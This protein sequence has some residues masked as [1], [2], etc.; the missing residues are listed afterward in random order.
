MKIPLKR[1]KD[2]IPAFAG[3]TY[4]KIPQSWYWEV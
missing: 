3:M 2:E 4:H 1:I